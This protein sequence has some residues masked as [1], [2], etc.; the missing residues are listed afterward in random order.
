MYRWRVKFL[1]QIDIEVEAPSEHEAIAKAF[2]ID[3]SAIPVDWEMQDP[4]PLEDLTP[5]M[6]DP[7]ENLDSELFYR[8]NP[9]G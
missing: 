4:E 5:A 8:E 1:K 9:D 2:Q 6:I 7:T 3:V